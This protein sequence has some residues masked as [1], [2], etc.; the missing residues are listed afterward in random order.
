M[1]FIIIGWLGVFLLSIVP[2][3][4]PNFYLIARLIGN[5][6][7]LLYFISLWNY[8]GMF[9]FS[10]NLLFDI[11]ILREDREEFKIK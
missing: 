6:L 5:S 10:F 4:F 2:F 3:K 7:I 11:I 8:I 1:I 9:V